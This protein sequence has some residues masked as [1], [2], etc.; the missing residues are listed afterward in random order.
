MRKVA[1]VAAEAAQIHER[2]R[3]SVKS[4]TMRESMAVRVNF[5][6]ANGGNEEC[7]RLYREGNEDVNG[8][9]I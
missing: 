7:E 3:E 4:F 1:A 8:G 9:G 2:R 6:V 5:L